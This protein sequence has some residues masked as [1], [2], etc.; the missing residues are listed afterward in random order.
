MV[1]SRCPEAATAASL[2]LPSFCMILILVNGN[3]VKENK[4]DC[5]IFFPGTLFLIFIKW[6]KAELKKL[7]NMQKASTGSS[8]T[9]S[10]VHSWY[11]KMQALL[12]PSIKHLCPEAELN[13]FQAKSNTGFYPAF[14][15]HP[16][17]AYSLR[18]TWC[19]YQLALSKPLFLQINLIKFC[20]PLLAMQDDWCYPI[21]DNPLRI[22][23]KL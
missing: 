17:G 18:A 3:F 16:W 9:E 22:L 1:A 6:E 5:N 19:A 4:W 7:L 10:L 8:I 13:I 11:H 23:L 15:N 14:K 21:S 2:F 20:L 12:R